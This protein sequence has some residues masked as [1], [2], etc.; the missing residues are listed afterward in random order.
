V[1]AK[2]INGL[3]PRLT[4][5]G[6]NAK[7]LADTTLHLMTPQ[8]LTVSAGIS[9]I[10]GLLALIS[11]FYYSYRIRKIETS[12]RSIRLVV[13]EKVSSMPTR[14]YKYFGSS[15]TTRLG[16]KHSRPSPQIKKP[17]ESTARSK[18]MLT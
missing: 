6:Y 10:I 15:K 4:R 17:N 16:W 1:L 8:V 2:D 9:G 11:Y 13:E 5:Q 7:V 3:E 14:Y 18:T 12:E